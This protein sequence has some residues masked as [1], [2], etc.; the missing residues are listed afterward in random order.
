MIARMDDR[1]NYR[2]WDMWL[3]GGRIGTHLVHHWPDD[4]LRSWRMNEIVARDVW[5]HVLR[6]LR[7]LGPR[8]P[9]SRSISTAEPQQTEVQTDRLEADDPHRVPL[10]VGQ[11]HT[12]SRIDHLGVHTLRIYDRA[13][14]PREAG[15]MAGAD[16]A[17]ALLRTPGDQSGRT[18][19]AGRSLRLV[20]HRARPRVAEA[21]RQAGKP[22]AEE[23]AIKK[24]GTYRTC[25]A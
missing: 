23:A 14:S 24:R 13:I 21:A 3:E 11:R 20:A 19:E 1:G 10:K 4:A 2:G 18:H 12:G 22:R 6:D 15:M 7:R 5:T 9:A 8:R 16:R 25:N 17:A